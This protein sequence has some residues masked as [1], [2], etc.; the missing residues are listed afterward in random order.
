MLTFSASD[1]PED[2]M[3]ESGNY[4]RNPDDDTG[5]P[6]CY[7]KD[8]GVTWDYCDIPQCIGKCGSYVQMIWEGGGSGEVV[9]NGHRLSITV[10]KVRVKLL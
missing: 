9:G 5:G 1:F 4:C 3:T 2:T 8:V 10:S 7:S 6:W